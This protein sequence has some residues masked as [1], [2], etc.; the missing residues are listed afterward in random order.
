M[1]SHAK[2]GASLPA[3]PQEPPRPVSLSTPTASKSSTGQ[4]SATSPPPCPTC[5]VPVI[6]AAQASHAASHPFLPTLEC[7][8]CAFFFW[9]AEK[10]AEHGETHRSPRPTCPICR[11][12]YVTH[13]ELSVHIRSA[14]TPSQML[15]CNSCSEPCIGLDGLREH[16]VDDHEDEYVICEKCPEEGV[17][18]QGPDALAAHKLHAHLDKKLL[19]G[20][21]NHMADDVEGVVRHRSTA[22]PTAF[23][24]RC[25]V[26]TMRFR[27]P[28]GLRVHERVHG[29]V[30]GDEEGKLK[31]GN[32]WTC[33]ECSRG[34]GTK[35]AVRRHWRKWHQDIRCELCGEGFGEISWLRWHEMTCLARL[36]VG[37]PFHLPEYTF[38]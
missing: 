2:P 11:T 23:P 7:S 17:F 22:H 15:F 3:K 33:P 24:L 26:C 5:H 32:V 38:G 6:P 18:Y 34:F 14:H 9:S 36:S 13:T 31:H 25:S 16:V 37:C 30:W 10:L 4:P 28:E 19:C 21:C 35:G 8:S 12:P 27:T 20:V 1:V 29:I